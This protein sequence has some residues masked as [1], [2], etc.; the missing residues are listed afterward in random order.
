ML[1]AAG[2]TAP[3]LYLYAHCL[4]GHPG[5]VALLAINADRTTVK[6]ISLPVP[7]DRYALSGELM[8]HIVKLNGHEVK[9]DANDDLPPLAGEAAKSGK[10]ELAPATITFFAIAAANNASCR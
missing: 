1:D 8:S 6:E 10:I 4:R 5:G 2:A 9:L 7:S 3:N